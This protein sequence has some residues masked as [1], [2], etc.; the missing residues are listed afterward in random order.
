VRVRL[1]IQPKYMHRFHAMMQCKPQLAAENIEIGPD[2]DNPDLIILQESTIREQP[3]TVAPLLAYPLAIY[4]RIGCAPVNTNGDVRRF[5][6]R[7]NVRA[8]L[9]ETDFVDHELNNETMI[10]GRYHLKLINTTPNEHIEK[11]PAVL[12]KA[13]EFAKIRHIFPIHMQARYDYLKT[14]RPRTLRKRPIEVFFAGSMVYTNKLVDRHR[15]NLVDKLV[16]LPQQSLVA[17]GN[18]FDQN[19]FQDLL[20]QAKIFVSPYGSGTYSWKDFEAIFAGCVL[21]KPK[22]DFIAHY[23]FPIYEPGKYCI[24]C[25]PNFSD[26]GAIVAEVAGNLPKYAEFAAAAQSALFKACNIEQYGADL[27]SF[28]RALT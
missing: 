27:T 14:L 12:L 28:F 1:E 16:K 10:D 9:K 21:I 15:L 24:Q 5:L 11:K 13:S 2:I 23:G 4:E 22:A 19:E 20:C 8:W 17:T 7:E 25:D 18:L 6:M 3:E 26:L